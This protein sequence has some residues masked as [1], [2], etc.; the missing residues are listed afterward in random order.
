MGLSICISLKP[1]PMKLRLS[2]LNILAFAI[3]ALALYL[4]FIHKDAGIPDF[5]GN[6]QKDFTAYTNK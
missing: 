3:L 5:S 4:N 6:Y 1:N 2:V